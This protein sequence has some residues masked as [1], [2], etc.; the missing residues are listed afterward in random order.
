MDSDSNLAI[1]VVLLVALC[2]GPL[3][4]SAF[5]YGIAGQIFF[6]EVRRLS[7]LDRLSRA[8]V[9]LTATEQYDAARWRSRIDGWNR[10]RNAVMLLVLL[11]IAPAACCL[12]GPLVIGAIQ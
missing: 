12:C 9:P 8:N 4:F 10:H 1:S 6:K 11:M 2:A 7:A 3:V 5:L